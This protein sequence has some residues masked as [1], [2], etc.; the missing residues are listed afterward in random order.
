MVRTISLYHVDHV[1]LHLFVLLCNVLSVAHRAGTQ[2][3]KVVEINTKSCLYKV[4]FKH[5]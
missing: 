3:N 1:G 4:L 2:S 5:S